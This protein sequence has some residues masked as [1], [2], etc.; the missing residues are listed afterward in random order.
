MAT[1]DDTREQLKRLGRR[2]AELRRGRGFTQERAAEG[3]GM[4][5]PNYARVEQGRQN[6]TVDTLVRIANLLDV[7]VFDLF[8]VPND[9]APPRPGRPSSRTRE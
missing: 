5:A 7:E 1:S 9:T 8:A 2:I 6:V 4:L 3:L